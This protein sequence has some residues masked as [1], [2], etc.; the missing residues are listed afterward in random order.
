MTGVGA[1][2]ATALFLAIERERVGAELVTPER[3]V[4]VRSQACRAHAP[5]AA[6]VEIAAQLRQHRGSAPRP[7]GVGLNLTQRDRRLR[8]RAVGMKHG[9]VRVLPPLL[10]QSGSTA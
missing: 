7:I 1:A 2:Y 4:E 3:R 6:L 5:L 9:I 8:Q 10:Q